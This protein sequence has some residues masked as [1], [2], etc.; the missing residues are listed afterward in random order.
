MAYNPRPV[1]R[2]NTS[3]R[4]DCIFYLRGLCFKGDAC[5]FKHDPYRLAT[6]VTPSGG[7]NCMSADLARIT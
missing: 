1:L 2:S 7:I 3:S 6:Q 4:P 5:P